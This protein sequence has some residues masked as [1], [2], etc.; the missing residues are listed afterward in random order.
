MTWH[1]NTAVVERYLGGALDRAAAA[2]VETHATGCA[3]CRS[4]LPDDPTWLAASWTDVFSGAVAPTPGHAER[5]LRRCGVPDHLARVIVMP[6]VAR[7]AWLVATGLA[8]I[9]AV[10]ASRFDAGP[11][12]Q[13]WLLVTAPL[14]PVAGVALTFSRRWTSVHALELA[15]PFDALRLLLIRSSTVTGVALLMAAIADLT[16]PSGS[17]AAAWLVPAL[18]LVIATLAL[19]TWFALRLAA[20]ATSMVWLAMIGVMTMAGD[21]LLAFGAIG[22]AGHVVVLLLAILV[23][24]KRS[25]AFDLGALR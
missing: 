14:A 8:F 23:L 25:R 17:L 15:A 11:T 24:A 2:S 10:S 19:G 7:R 1:V 4:L 12:S 22:Q 18:A 20:A 13:M 3:A 5:G 6:V 9:F 16:T 21:V